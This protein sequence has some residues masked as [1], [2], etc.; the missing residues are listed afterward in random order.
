MHVFCKKCASKI[1][2]ADR[3][4]GL[5]SL[6]NVQVKGNVHIEGGGIGF[7][8]GGGI[9]F[10]PGGVVGFGPPAKSP[11]TCPRCRTTAEYGADEIKGD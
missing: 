8:P 11:F 2:V 1:V 10:G 5:T 4:S 7:G 3:P 6:G 9:A